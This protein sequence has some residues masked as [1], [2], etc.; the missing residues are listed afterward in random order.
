MRNTVDE[1]DVEFLAQRL[2]KSI[3]DAEAGV[4]T[5]TDIVRTLRETALPRMDKKA[6][7]DI[8]AIVHNA[9]IVTRNGWKDNARLT[10][11]YDESL[12]NVLVFPGELGQVMINLIVNAADAIEE[13]RMRSDTDNAPLG[14]IRLQTRRYDGGCEIR[15]SDTGSGIPGEVQPHIFDYFFTTK[16]PGKGTGQGLAIVYDAVTNKHGGEITFETEIGQGTT[17]VIRLPEDTG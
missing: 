3:D 7:S 14:E 10:E 12:E 5:V 13:Q 17:F 6:A 9:S 8:N 2:P 1:G 11:T 15:V 16:D 4:G